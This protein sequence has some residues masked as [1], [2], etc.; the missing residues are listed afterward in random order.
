M[1]NTVKKIS[2]K[3]LDHIQ[4]ASTH[5]ELYKISPSVINRQASASVRV[6]ISD[7]VEKADWH[8]AAE[9]CAEL[10]NNSSHD[11]DILTIFA[12]SLT[13][14]GD[15]ERANIICD[16]IYKISDDKITY[17]ELIE[18]LAIL[19]LSKL[20]KKPSINQG[21]IFIK[22]ALK[23]LKLQDHAKA[24]SIL[25]IFVDNGFCSFDVYTLLG[26]LYTE[27]KSAE[28]AIEAYT[29]AT[30]I[31]P[32]HAYPFTKKAVLEF[33]LDHGEAIESRKINENAS[34]V[35][36]EYLGA[37]GRFGNQLLQYALGY[38]C[39]EKLNFELRTSDW[40]G[41]DLFGL[42]DPYTEQTS[43]K[44]TIPENEVLDLI[45]GRIT[46]NTT[47]S[48]KGY[49]CGSTSDW[50]CGK[51]TF[52]KIFKPSDKILK[53]SSLALAKLKSEKNTIIAI[54]LR[55]GDFGSDKFWIAPS[56]WYL[57]W[58]KTIWTK[59]HNPLL[60]IATDDTTTLK[61]F[62]AY[63][64]L[65][66]IDICKPLHGAEFFL[67]HWIMQNSDILATSN[68][69]FSITAALLNNNAESLWRPD[70]KTTTIRQFS[71][72]EEPILI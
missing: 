57:D 46:I 36:L 18:S 58:L 61:E 23:F 25:K 50:S 14:I 32:G 24:I 40:I 41:R 72:W 6:K 38:L 67:D 20:E 34:C 31:I 51:K 16:F 27:V 9:L 5:I 45:N 48:I 19:Y 26:D 15:F 60:Y 28:N 33:R 1:Q 44:P 69:T 56:K 59:A 47:V 29:K 54:H 52:R 64:P 65:K 66:A 10:V 68:S 4:A 3:T 43:K 62:Q 39:A 63:R 35:Q 12:F 21:G 49:F 53:W 17:H 30:E 22:L 7:A 42:D 37:D 2:V 70:P 55:R 8:E 11:T 71:P 13:H